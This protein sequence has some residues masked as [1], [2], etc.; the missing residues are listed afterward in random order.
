MALV[1]NID[2]PITNVT[3]LADLRTR[4]PQFDSE[5][6]YVQKHT[7]A[8]PVG[9]SGD[10]GGGLFRAM[11]EVP[12]GFVDDNGITV[13]AEGTSGYV[14]VLDDVQAVT[15]KMFGAY[16]NAPYIDGRTIQGTPYPKA[17]SMGAADLTG[18]RNDGAE[19][20]AAYDASIKYNLPLLI[21]EPIYM[22]STRI[23]ISV[24]R[25]EGTSLN[26]Q[27][28]NARRS[29]IYTSGTGG[30]VL[31][32]WGHNLIVENIAFRNA[33][34]A[35]AGSPLILS[36]ATTAN[37]GGGKEYRIQNVEF[38]HYKYAF[39][40]LTFVGVISNIYMYDCAYGM[41]LSGNTSTAISSVWAHHCDIGYL[42]GYGIDQ[43]TLEPVAGGAPLLYVTATNIAADGCNTPH[44]VGGQV[45]SVTI[46]GMGIEG[47]NGSVGIDFSAYAGDDDQFKFTVEGLS[48]WIQSKMNTGVTRFIEMPSN[49]SRM[50]NGSIVLK[51]GYLKAD[52]QL[53]LI[54]KNSSGNVEAYGNSLVL[55][56]GFRFIKVTDNSRVADNRIRSTTMQGRVYGNAPL[57]GRNSYDGTTVSA[58][59]VTAGADFNE[60]R[61]EQGTFVLPWN[62]AVDILLTT[63][64]EESR[65]GACFLAGDL[66][67]IPVNKNGLG[68]QE[69]GGLVQFS[70]SGSTEANVTSGQVW[71]NKLGKATSSSTTS[72]D[73]I[74]ITKIV[75]NNQTY[76]RVHAQSTASVSM[77]MCHLTLSYSGFSHY[78][79][80]RW[81][82]TTV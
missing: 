9:V 4:T 46:V 59:A 5:L 64:G 21:E 48:C 78:Y 80:R 39:P 36:N 70:I 53:N 28:V 51:D 34:A 49:E 16:M 11:L 75:K 41:G 43:T 61:T 52:Y 73:A 72:L 45:R 38:Y 19:M 26:L 56:D 14:R 24:S 76:L 3:E 6:V 23:D 82:L 15:P 25:W 66:S 57:E 33:D 60:V 27:G 68:G 77:F 67:L 54:N 8:A 74:S 13:K 81:S 35:Y 40:T 22:G 50:P 55:G 17:P 30:F 44:K 47:I 37:G 32:S 58:V 42:W 2:A 1:K 7:A 79:D 29:I 62:R 71:F 10:T 63:K 18:V 69:A 65:Y 12:A 31:T 20:Q